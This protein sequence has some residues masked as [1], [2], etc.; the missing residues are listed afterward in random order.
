MD[1]PATLAWPD[2][3]QDLTLQI[4][5]HL[6]LWTNWS[7]GR[8]LGATLTMDRQQANFLIAFTASFVVF[9]GSRF[10]RIIC[11]VLHQSYSTS[12]SRDALHHQRQVLL[13]NSGSSDS[14]VVSHGFIHVRVSASLISDSQ[15]KFIALFHAWRG[16]NLQAIIRTAPALLLAIFCTIAFTIAGGFSS[17]IQFG[18]DDIGSAVLIDGT[19]CGILSNI[20]SFRDQ[21]ALEKVA[22]R[23]FDTANNYVQQCYSAN[24]TGVTDCKHF[25]S[26][27]LPGF[28][29]NMAP[30]PFKDS[31]C[32]SNSTN[33][34]L[35]TG[36]LDSHADLG[37]NAPPDERMFLR[38]K[39]QCAPLLTKG[40][41]SVHGNYTRYNYGPQYAV[42]GTASN[43]SKGHLDYTYE[44]ENIDDQYVI[45]D[46]KLMAEQSYMLRPLFA[47]TANGIPGAEPSSTFVPDDE[48]GRA[49]AD[50]LIVF[51]SGHGVVFGEPLDDDWYRATVPFATAANID[52]EDSLSVYRTSEAA[53]PLG[54]AS[55]WQFCSSNTSA[56]GPMASYFDAIS[57]AAEA[58][59]ATNSESTS[60]GAEAADRLDW[61]TIATYIDALSE[62]S[63]LQQLQDNALLSKQN[64]FGGYQGSV[65]N[66]QWQLDVT[67]WFSITLAAMQTS[68]LQ[69][70]SGF[71]ITDESTAVLRPQT[72][73][74][75]KLCSNQVCILRLGRLFSKLIVPKKIRTTRYSSFSLFGL[76]F[77]YMLGGLILAI[78]YSLEP[79]LACLHRRR[80][81]RQYAYL[82][83]MTNE[84]LQLHRLAHEGVDG[85]I[86][87]WSRCE[88]WVPTTAPGVLLTSLDI[89][90]LKHPKL[91]SS[92][93]TTTL[94][95]LDVTQT[96]SPP[97][98]TLSSGGT[99]LEPSPSSVQHPQPSCDGTNL[100]TNI[101]PETPQ[102][103]PPHTP[104]EASGQDVVHHFEPPSPLEETPCM[105]TS[106]SDRQIRPVQNLDP[107][108]PGRVGS[109]PPRT[110][111]TF[112]IF[113]KIPNST[114]NR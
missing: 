17:Q 106:Q 22:A 93:E 10:W 84:T 45:M 38:H 35:D 69:T 42:V 12:E 30:C 28:M 72:E 9:V 20:T 41:V 87:G 16:S 98:D 19:N 1:H 66:N 89:S 6:G 78:S 15:F 113:P 34:Y 55:Q 64:L 95:S 75:R 44:V 94:P 90:D 92:K 77:T 112:T 111:T 110:H 80:K 26:Q 53:S 70:T 76:L 85:A 109:A 73:A 74:A 59:G 60:K 82:E 4:K 47:G 37:S 31:L 51:L 23:L 56:C 52:E 102:I 58:F 3:S 79:I 32:R 8:V 39:L 29:E 91:H 11:L 100:V 68:L 71:M 7:Q 97:S 21:V 49:D 27:R 96:T 86:G 18:N 54:C 88:S 46:N 14:G 61:L 48:L 13:R 105:N 40:R 50:I 43:F 107:G 2:G 108:I 25:A 114:K 104:L 101:D 99:D 33:L 81:Y 36:F 62:A 65:P 5:I 83:W 57:G 103:S 63:M 67:N 24:S